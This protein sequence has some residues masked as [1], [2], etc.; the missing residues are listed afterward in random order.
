M[1]KYFIILLYVLYISGCQTDEIFRVDYKY[2]YFPTK[3]GSWISYDIDSLAYNNFFDPV[4]IDTFRFQIKELI[5][6]EFT[7]N[8]GRPAQR[9][10]RYKRNNPSEEWQIYRAWHQLL[11]QNTAER[12]E[13]NVRF[14]KL[15]FPPQS[16]TTWKGNAYI[17]FDDHLNCEYLATEW[18]YAYQDVDV[19]RTIGSYTFDST[20]TV[21]QVDD[22]NFICKNYWK[23]TYAKNIGLVEKQII[24]LHDTDLSNPNLPIGE[25]AKE[26]FILHTRVIA[27]GHL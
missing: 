15:I 16:N 22:E 27:F 8:E 7:D 1:R 5:E 4:R 14:V 26:G 25:R 19:R 21:L 3:I 11:T 6:S 18:E 12:I 2:E 9:I 24:R 23:E 10:V 13:E 17:D 20:L